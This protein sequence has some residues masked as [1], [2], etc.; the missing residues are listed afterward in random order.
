MKHVFTLVALALMSRGLAQLPDYVPSDG[1]VAWYPLDGLAYDAGNYELDGVLEGPAVAEDRYGNLNGALSFD[2]VDDRVSIPHSDLTNP[3]VL[4]LSVWFKD[5][6]FSNSDGQQSQLISKREFTGWGN[7]YEFGVGY[8]ITEFP[9]TPTIYSNFSVNGNHTIF[10]ASESIFENQWHQAVYCHG[11]DSLFIYLDGERVLA[12]ISPGPLPTNNELPTWFGGRPG[13]SGR[14]FF[15]GL[16]DDIGIWNR[17]LSHEEILALYISEQPISGCTD[18]AACNYES[19][20]IVDD[21]SCIF[22]PVI[23]LGEDIETCEDSV[24]LD[25]GEGFNFYEWSTGE[26]TQTIVV[27]ET[28]EYAVS[29]SNLTE[30]NH[31]LQFNGTDASGAP[32]EP[33]LFGTESFSVS[34]DCRLNAF[35]G[36][37]SEPY[38]YIIG[39]PLTQGTGDHGFKIQTAGTSLNGGYQVHINDE[40]T[41]HFNVIS[42]DN[43]SGT[44]VELD[45]W[46]DLTMVVDRDNAQFSFYV[47][48]ALIETQTI[49]PDFGNVD[50]PNGMSLGVQSIHGS[51]LLNGDLDNLQIWDVALSA[52]EVAHWQTTV[53]SGSETGLVG[54]WD[55]EEGEGDEAYD[56]SQVAPTIALDNVGWTD[57]TPIDVFDASCAASDTIQV[58]WLIRGCT[59]PE[60]CNYVEDASCDDG[61]CASCEALQTA[62]GPGTIWDAAMQMCIGDGSGDIN[63]DGCVQLNDLLDLLS[64]YGNCEAEEEPWVCGDPLDYQGCDYETVQIGEQC[65]F[66]ENARFLPEVS[67][68]SLGSEVDGLPHAYVY[69]YNGSVVSEAVQSSGYANGALYNFDAVI[70]WEICPAGWYVPSDEDWMTLESFLG[71]DENELEWFYPEQGFERGADEEIGFKLKSVEWDGG[72]STGFS[73]L[74]NGW[75]WAGVFAYPEYTNFWTSTQISPEVSWARILREGESGIARQPYYPHFGKSVRCVQE[76]E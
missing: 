13:G 2:G 37:D 72:N 75:R 33:I 40:G 15:S 55:F 3:S 7:A 34:V 18:T 6:D 70:S 30:N 63:L 73:A 20:A 43:N 11:E 29:A 44:N 69:G 50:H 27:T 47:D 1:L 64:A 12:Q 53:P 58:S 60:A 26:T 36:N 59:D 68:S 46:Y 14:N 24:V 45:Q 76:S 4:T 49:H 38:S 66:A 10:H 71:M 22:P 54:Y 9:E 74:S 8:P 32:A 21:G 52:E 42:F 48:G 17:V 65:W 28:G 35:K 41:T 57:N 31:A 61:T 51:S 39:H 23:A 16:L 62:C 19:N 67:P 25:A 56:V 5:S